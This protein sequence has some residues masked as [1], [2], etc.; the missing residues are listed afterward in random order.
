MELEPVNQENRKPVSP[1]QP[2]KIKRVLDQRN[3]LK[4]S[5][6]FAIQTEAM[7]QQFEAP[8]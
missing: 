7:I 5:A 4:L 2:C 8:N 6:L 3:L 1:G